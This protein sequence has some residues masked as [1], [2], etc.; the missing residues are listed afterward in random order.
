MNFEFHLEIYLNKEITTRTRVWLAR[1]ERPQG[2]WISIRC[3]R[4][5]IKTKPPEIR[6][7]IPMPLSRWIKYKQFLYST[8]HCIQLHIKQ[9]IISF[10]R[11]LALLSRM[12]PSSAT[13]YNFNPIHC[14]Y[15]ATN[16]RINPSCCKVAWLG[17]NF[18]N[19]SDLDAVRPCWGEQDPLTLFLIQAGTS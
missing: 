10:N 7:G 5:R 12:M 15:L 8:I 1:E 17:R 16:N 3:T 14:Q 6:T 18:S 9:L 2:N 11:F 13:L 4:T 19:G